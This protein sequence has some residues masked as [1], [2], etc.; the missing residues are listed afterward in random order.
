MLIS[1]AVAGRQA[2]KL[3]ATCSSVWRCSSTTTPAESKRVEKSMIGPPH[4]VSN[5][6]PIILAQPENETGQ[7]RQLRLHHLAM[8]DRNHQ[9]WLAHNM[10]FEQDKETF[11]TRRLKGGEAVLTESGALSP[12]EFATFYKDFLVSKKASLREYNRA[13]LRDITTF[14][15]L[16]LKVKTQKLLFWKR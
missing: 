2:R 8:N 5:I 15:W 7:E 16:S 14:M 3:G 13:W 6:S 9:F 12:D 4:P 1:M 11:K 10:Q